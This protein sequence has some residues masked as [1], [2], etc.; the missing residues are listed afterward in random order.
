[1]REWARQSRGGQLEDDGRR[2]LMMCYLECP[3]NNQCTPLPPLHA[4]LQ[5]YFSR[6]KRITITILA[7]NFGEA[8]RYCTTPD[9]TF[10]RG[11]LLMQHRSCLCS[12]LLL[13]EHFRRR[14][15]YTT[16]WCVSDRVCIV[17]GFPQ[18][19]FDQ[20]RYSICEAEELVHRSRDCVLT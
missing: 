9:T 14:F 4:S 6:S 16:G 15:Q 19:L 2:T 1:M 11:S 17:E 5:C 7:Y 12:F 13:C 8:D 10:I 18:N 20:D 3:S